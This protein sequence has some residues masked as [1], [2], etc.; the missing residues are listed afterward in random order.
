MKGV[1]L[2]ALDPMRLVAWHR[3]ASF[4]ARCSTGRH[5]IA[6]ERSNLFIHGAPKN[7]IRIGDHACIDG[8]IEVYENGRIEIGNNFFL[9]R[10]RIY[11]AHKISIGNYVLISD[12]V[13]VMDSNLHPM[14]ATLR[15]EISDSWA[16][17]HFPDVYNEI[18]GAGVDIGDDVW[19]G[20]GACI[21]KGVKIGQGA[22]VGAGSVVTSDVAAWTVVSGVPA[23]EVRLIDEHD[24]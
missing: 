18:P 7:A 20:Y 22:V 3:T 16:K 21:L 19:I 11:C 15:R 23:R 24:R 13:S 9:G 10:S 2:K 5:L 17:G 6:T 1:L 14:R 8:T 12:S 4:R